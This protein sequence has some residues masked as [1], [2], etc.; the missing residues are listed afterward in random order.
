MAALHEANTICGVVDYDPESHRSIADLEWPNITISDAYTIDQ[1]GISIRFDGHIPVH[2][3]RIVWE[4][5]EKV[6]EDALLEELFGAQLTQIMAT[7]RKSGLTTISF[8][9]EKPQRDALAE[10]Q[11]KSPSTPPLLKRT[12]GGMLGKASLPAA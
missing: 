2:P 3:D 9:L 5:S 12:V 11:F 4:E 1:Y 6:G 10:L 8:A 7:V